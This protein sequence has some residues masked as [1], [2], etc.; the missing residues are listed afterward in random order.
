MANPLQPK[1]VKILEQEYNAFVI[2][3]IN[4]SKSGIADIIACVPTPKLSYFVSDCKCSNYHTTSCQCPPKKVQ[5]QGKFY[6][7]EVKWGSDQ[8]SELQKQKINEVLDAGGLAYFVRSESDLRN[9][10]DNNIPPIRY[11][12]SVNIVI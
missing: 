10:L 1:C 6:A 8:P 12:P 5:S 3:T 9:I 2:V 4:T 7:F 11:S